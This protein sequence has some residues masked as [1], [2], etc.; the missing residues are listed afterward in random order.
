MKRALL[1]I[2]LVASAALA[3]DAKPIKGTVKDTE[4]NALAGV[5]VSDGLHAVKTD[6]KGRYEMDA[7]SE[8]DY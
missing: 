1:S 4:G 7:D 3:A 2:I 6:A 5:V 8:S